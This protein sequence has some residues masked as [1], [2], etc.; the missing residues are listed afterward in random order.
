[1][2]K[3][4]NRGTAF[5]ARP[6]FN[7][8]QILLWLLVFFFF[9]MPMVRL[10]LMSLKGESGW[11]LAHYQD[12]FSQPQT[13][14]I[15]KNT[16]ILVL[17]AGFLALALGILFAWLV[18]YTDIRGK[19]MIQLLI[20][21]PFVIPSYILALAWIQFIGN[22]GLV[23]NLLDLIGIKWGGL[24]LYS[25]MGMIL[26]MAVTTFPLVFMFT[27]NNFRQI[28]REAELAARV[29]GASQWQ[30]FKRVTIPMGLPGIV[31]GGFIAFLACLD[32]FGIPSFL[33]TPANISVLTTHIYQNVIGFGTSSFNK[34]SVLSVVLAMVALLGNLGQWFL[35]RKTKRLETHLL[36]LQ[37]RIVLGKARP[38]VEG[39]I[40][41]FFS[42]VTIFPLLALVVK[43]FVKA[44]GLPFI[45]QNFSLKNYLYVLNS[46]STREAITVSVKLS[47]VTAL[48]GI[49]LGVAFAYVRVRK[50][51]HSQRLMESAITLP[52]ALPGTVFALAMIFTWMKPI[53]G[54]DWNPG[55]YG[56]IW[57]LYITY[58][59]RFMILQVRSGVTA[60][61]QVDVSVEE[62]ARVSGTNQWGKWA[63][64]L[65]PLILPTILNGTVLVFLSALTELTVSS[66]LYAS[67]SQ[68]IGVRILSMQHSGYSLYATAFSALIV[69]LIILTYFIIEVVNKLWQRKVVT[70]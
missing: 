11:T 60:F 16:L 39:L 54:L 36:D 25:M 30:T 15:L 48:V 13:Y 28:P 23:K 1:M 49:L 56:S 32:N 51:N 17:G 27:L 68:T 14:Q 18:A 12:I 2:Q 69:V 24:N 61:Q 59:T 19:K 31:G 65:I 44:I 10:F 35:L 58:I 8:S 55:I 40:G 20:F 62:A 43:P 29:S 26:V 5:I 46:P 7:L 53:P 52:Y 34:A 37:P 41:L 3:A 38:W 22:Q 63:K 4:K 42:L 9:V 64:V 57:V 33:G 21:L 45:P 67:D 66:L 47:L 50:N 6:S 70:K